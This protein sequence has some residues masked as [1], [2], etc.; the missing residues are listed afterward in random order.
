LNKLFQ[1]ISQR[2]FEEG[3]SLSALRAFFAG[4]SGESSRFPGDDEFRK[5]LLSNPVYNFAPGD[6]I[7]DILWELE[8]RSRSKFAEKTNRPA[9]LW[10]EHVLP[11]SWTEAY[12]FADGDFVE[13]SSGDPRATDRNRLLHS[14][15]N[16]TLISGALNISSGNRGFLEKREKYDEHTSLFLNKW[17]IKH[18]AWAEAEI[19]ERG[20]RL[21]EMA[22]LIWPGLDH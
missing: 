14:L 16:L 1:G 21:A 9:G 18:Q 4:R 3:V 2:F 22:M 19:R 12:P 13:R 5:G 20:E 10:T 7:K 15:G 17:F 6:R 8:L 11:I